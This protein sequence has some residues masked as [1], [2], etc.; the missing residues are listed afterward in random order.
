MPRSCGARSAWCCRRTCSST[1]ACAR[2]SPSP[3]RPRRSRRCCRRARS[4]G[5]MRSAA[6]LPRGSTPPPASKGARSRAVFQ[7][8]WQMRHELTGPKRMA[9]EAAFLPA[10]LSLQATPAHPAPR[11]VALAI[12]AL[13]VIALVWSLV[14]EIDIVAVAP[15]RIVVSDRTKTLQPL[16]ASVVKRVLVK[17]G[18]AVQAGQ[19][20]VELD[21]TNATADQSSVR[22][23]LAAAVSEERRTSALLAALSASRTPTLKGKSSARDEG[24]LQAEW[25]DISAKLGKLAAEHA[26]RE[27]EIAT[28]RELIA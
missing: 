18:D 1:A 28:V 23:Q 20:L 5:R 3:T 21:A 9:D 12:C 6:S 25:L 13:F 24:Q 17:D 19:L 10:A 26:H 7:A 16:E 22:E 11:R 15:G 8:A 2:T 14:G 27:A 4:P